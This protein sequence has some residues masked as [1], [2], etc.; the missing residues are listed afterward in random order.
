LVSLEKDQLVLE[1]GSVSVAVLLNGQAPQYPLSI[2][3]QVSGSSDSDDHDLESGVVF[4]NS[5]TQA[6]IEFSVAADELIEGDETLVITLRDVNRGVQ[7]SHTVTISE[8]SLVPALALA[9]N[10]AVKQQGQSRLTVDND[11]FV[12]IE[13]QVT[14]S[15]GNLSYV[16]HAVDSDVIN[17]SD[18][19]AIFSFDPSMLS[20]GLYHINLEV[21]DDKKTITTGV[22]IKVIDAFEPLSAELDFD[23]DGIS[24]AQEGNQD[25]DG[26]GIADYQDRISECN[27]L[28]QQIAEQDGYLVEGE[29]GVCLRLG[30]ISR[31]S[32]TGGAHVT[33]AVSGTTDPIL[34]PD[35][36]AIEVGGVFDFVADGLSQTSPTVAIVLPQRNPIPLGGVYRKYNPLNGWHDFESTPNGLNNLMSTAGESGYCPPPGA[37]VWQGGL[38]EGYWCV[39][40]TIEDGGPNDYDGK[41]NGTVVD[42]GYVGVPNNGNNLP[43][44][45]AASI[46]IYL[47]ETVD[48]DI[49]DYV[50]DVDGDILT[51]SS[52]VS[53]GGTVPFNGRVLS[54]QAASNYLGQ[55]QITYGISD[56]LGGTATG[57]IP[58]NIIK[59]SYLVTA[60]TTSSGSVGMWCLGLFF[61]LI[62]RRRSRSTQMN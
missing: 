51:I 15:Q 12:Y 47:N 23:S 49:S 43:T 33:A 55:D 4:I 1:G 35:L 16:W 29:A 45:T 44:A 53:N 6:K 62:L 36:A 21:T 42:P 37:D 20:S 5:G 46:D 32:A 54:Y 50:D 31:L 41:K 18:N 28:Q 59:R 14:H 30:S 61:L 10:L 58:L 48:I 22:V 39:Q 2:A 60:R 7:S 40:L 13:S 26:D 8:N 56:G 34:V 3:Y 9:V 27:V 19:E 52:A 38:I 17:V 24:D 11:H 57:K 25:S